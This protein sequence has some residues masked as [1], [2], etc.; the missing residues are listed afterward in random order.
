MS[1]I[2]L[3]Y[4]ELSPAA[5]KVLS[6][7][8]ARMAEMLL[9]AVPQNV[10]DS[11]IKNSGS[12]INFV[13]NLIIRDLFIQSIAS[14]H[15]LFAE[16]APEINVP[17]LEALEQA[18]VDFV[19]LAGAYEELEKTGREPELVLGPVNLSLAYWRKIYSNLRAWQD[20]NDPQSPNKLQRR[21]G[22]DGLWVL[23][24][25]EHHYD[26]IIGKDL[27]SLPGTRIRGNGSEAA[28]ITGEGLQTDEIIWRAAV[29][30]TEDTNK[31]IP[32]GQYLTLQAERFFLRKN[33]VDLDG[34]TKLGILSHTA[35]EKA[36]WISQGNFGPVNGQVYLFG[37]E[38][39]TGGQNSDK[40]WG[41][42]RIPVWG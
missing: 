26:E 24:Y 33:P 30:P 7:Y 36:H 5:L 10:K 40:E 23:E 37:Y 39:G 18:D 34:Y 1:L 20:V 27:Y 35:G 4:A 41:N 6:H 38:T 14:I 2:T 29:I 31:Y 42:V 12:S 28:A 25:I 9:S 32:I 3:R 19:K 11:A 8:G 22:G 16:I 13:S 17:A 15:Y 21:Q